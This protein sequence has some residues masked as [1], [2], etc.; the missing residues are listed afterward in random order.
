MC[1]DQRWRPG[2]WEGKKG[3]EE[4]LRVVWYSFYGESPQQTG[5]R[6]GQVVL[7]LHPA[8]DLLHHGPVCEGV[9]VQERRSAVHRV[10]LLGEV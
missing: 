10:L 9:G 1:R 2:H 6:D 4:L 5:P 8:L 7:Q 3:R